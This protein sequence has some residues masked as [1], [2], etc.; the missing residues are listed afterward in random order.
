MVVLLVDSAGLEV[1]LSKLERS[2]ARRN[3][4]VY[5]SREQISSVQLT[6]D[7]WSWLRGKPAPGTKLGTLSAYGTFTA[8]NSTDFVLL[9]KGPG[10]VIDIEGGEFDRLLLTS[11]NGAELARALHFPG[12]AVEL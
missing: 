9:R 11:V 1:S 6:D 2:F 4:N 10:V 12:E 3:D 5:V 8:A 7:P